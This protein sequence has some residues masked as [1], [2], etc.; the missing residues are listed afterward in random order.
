LRT[1]SGAGGFR[2]LHGVRRAVAD[3]PFNVLFLCTGNSARSI[4]AEAILNKLGDGKFRAYSAHGDCGKEGP[5]H[6]GE[7]NVLQVGE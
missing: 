3:H 2:L 1:G 7:P 4:I 6:V 5:C